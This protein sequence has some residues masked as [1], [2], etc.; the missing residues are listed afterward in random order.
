M[1]NFQKSEQDGT[2]GNDPLL[3]AT[4]ANGFQNAGKAI[5]AHQEAQERLRAIFATCDGQ[6][7]PE[8]VP[9]GTGVLARYGSER[10]PQG[11]LNRFPTVDRSM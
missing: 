7:A 11:L 6:D 3:V 4:V 1:G 9:D 8:G 2:R 10:N 5:A